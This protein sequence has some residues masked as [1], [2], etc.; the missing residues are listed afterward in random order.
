MA[1]NP[2]YL[3][4]QSRSLRSPRHRRCLPLTAAIA[5]SPVCCADEE[6]PRRARASQRSGV[7]YESDDGNDEDELL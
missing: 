2:D 3:V 1:T 4:N 5:A 7:G 6:C